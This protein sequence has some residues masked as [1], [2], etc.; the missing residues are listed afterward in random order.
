MRFV[1]NHGMS[2]DV[3]LPSIRFK[4]V[5]VLPILIYPVQWFEVTLLKDS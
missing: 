4:C 5:V 2:N 1:F 3:L